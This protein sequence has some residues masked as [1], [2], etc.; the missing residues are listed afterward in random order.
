MSYIKKDPTGWC[1]QLS[2]SKACAKHCDIVS[3]LADVNTCVSALKE[4]AH[5]QGKTV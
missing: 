3:V 2:L 5:V 4:K 1:K